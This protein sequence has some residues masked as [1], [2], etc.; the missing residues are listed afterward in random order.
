MLKKILM[1]LSV[2]L[3]VTKAYA[4]EIGWSTYPLK[5]NQRILTA[6]FGGVFSSGGGM[7]VTASYLQ[8]LSQKWDVEAGAGFT[9]GERGFTLYGAGNYEIYPD[10]EKQPKVSIKGWYQYSNEY[11]S[12]VNRF[13]ASPL[14]SK[15]TLLWGNEAFPYLAIPTGV[16]L[17][18]DNKQYSLFSALTLGISGNIPWEKMK[19][20]AMI[21]EGRLNITG[22]YS[23]LSFGFSHPI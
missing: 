12:S 5:E 6:Q 4:N 21:L 17:N 19:N 2:S 7:G 13:Y 15:S 11:D 1:I 9:G 16:N 8:K 14:V 23:G 20:M 10:Y 3:L 22:S 18:Y